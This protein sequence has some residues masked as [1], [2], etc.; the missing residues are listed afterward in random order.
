MQIIDLE[1]IAI[2]TVAY[3]HFTKRSNIDSIRNNGLEPR[4]GDASLHV[5][6]KARVCYSKGLKGMLGMINS[7]IYVMK[8]CSICNIPIGYRQYFKIKDFSSEEKL[9]QKE[10]YEACIKKMKDEVYLLI[11]AQEGVDFNIEDMHGICAYDIKG[12][13]NQGIEKEKLK[14]VTSQ[15]G[16]SVLDIVIQVYDKFIKENPRSEKSIKLLFSDLN[17]IIEYMKEKEEEMEL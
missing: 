2:S 16:N 10:I 8:N 1:T 12:K 9:P 6:D 15:K 17:G 5:K 7:F 13:E 4:I 11:D 3:F 14:I